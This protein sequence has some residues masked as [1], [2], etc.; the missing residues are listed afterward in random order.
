MLAVVVEIEEKQ[1]WRCVWLWLVAQR[2]LL[3]QGNSL[4]FASQCN[5]GARRKDSGE[6]CHCR[7]LGT[8]LS[9]DDKGGKLIGDLRGYLG[10][11]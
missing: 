2:R 6:S 1:C 3:T 7:R 10:A 4:G 9:R 8:Y 11:L 5:A